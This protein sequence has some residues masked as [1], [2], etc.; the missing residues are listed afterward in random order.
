[1]ISLLFNSYYA[2]GTHSSAKGASYALFL[3]LHISG[4]V[5]LGVK[6]VLGDR[7]TFFGASVYAKTAALTHIGVKSYFSQFIFLL[8]D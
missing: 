7:K 5:T 3:F 8:F 2:I 1:M 6:L 4:R